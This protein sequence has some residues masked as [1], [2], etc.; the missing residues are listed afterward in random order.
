[1]QWGAFPG[2]ASPYGVE[3]L[4]GN[5][6]EWT[7]SLWGTDSQQPTFAYPYR[8]DDGRE[9]LQAP[10]DMPRILR[11]GSFL[12]PQWSMRCVYR[13]RGI[14]QGVSNCIGFRVVI[15]GPPKH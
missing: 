14:V 12:H 6:W 11:G 9:D 1:M 13:L 7:R 5:V 4:S 2:G 10:I 3:E 15:V 8:I